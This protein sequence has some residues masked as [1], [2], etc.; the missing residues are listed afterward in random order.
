MKKELKRKWVKALLS[1]KYK[2][3]K[4]WLRNEGKYCCLGVLRAVNKPGDKRSALGMDCLLTRDQLKETGL[5]I[6]A[7][8]KLVELNDAG[9]PFDMIA[10]LIDQEL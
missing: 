1:G 10:G 8:S 5:S 7:Q 6:Q 2:Q 3:G 4:Y 9:V